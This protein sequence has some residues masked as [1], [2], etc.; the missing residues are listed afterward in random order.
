MKRYIIICIAMA[1]GSL[2]AK[3]QTECKNCNGSGLEDRTCAFC[4]GEGW[5]ECDFCLGKKEVRCNMCQ[6]SGE[7]VC[8]HC[9]GRGGTKVKDEWRTCQ[10]CDGKGT[11]E[12]VECKGTKTKVCWKCEG[13]GRYVCNQCHGDR[14]NKWQCHVCGGTGQVKEE[15]RTVTS[16]YTDANGYSGT[17]QVKIDPND[18]EEEKMRKLTKA[19]V[20]HR[21]Q[22][23]KKNG[24][25]V[26]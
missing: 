25:N 9:H 19:R 7:V 8:A 4:N 10:Y 20:D 13:A 14:V 3:A 2:Y 5:R 18:S 23:M 15:A 16:T 21:L 22:Q 1:I 26:K 6:G 17:V 24:V 11:P 12:C